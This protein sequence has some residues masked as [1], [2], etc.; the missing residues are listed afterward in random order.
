MTTMIGSCQQWLDGVAKVTGRARFTADLKL[1]G[2][3]HVR[4]LVS[5]YPSATI[6]VIDAAAASDLPGVIRVTGADLEGTAARGPDQGARV[7][8][9]RRMRISPRVRSPRSLCG[10]LRSPS[11]T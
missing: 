5:P 10:V 4:I 8:A 3:A 6:A 11:P 1:P 2:L 7:T 9:S